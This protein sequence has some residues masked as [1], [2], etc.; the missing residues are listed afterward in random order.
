VYEVPAALRRACAPWTLPEDLGDRLLLSDHLEP[1]P[2]KADLYWVYGC[3]NGDTVLP[4]LRWVKRVLPF[5]NASVREGRA[6]HVI[7]VGHEEGWAEVWSLLGRWLG[8]NFDHSNSRRGWDDLHPASP[9]RQLASIQ[10]HGGSDYTADGKPRRRG[11]SGGAS[12]RVCFQP[13]KDVVVPGFPGIMDY[14]DDHG[15]PA[16]YKFG[17]GRESSGRISQC[18]R[19]AQ[20]QPYADG[21]RELSPRRLSPRLFMAGAIQTKTH[22]P[23]LYEASRVVPYECWKNRSKPHDFQ[24]VQTETVTVSVS[25]WEIERPVDPYP[26]TRHASLCAVPEGKIGSY[27]HRATNS[28]MLGCVPLI[29]KERFSYEILHEVIDWKSI[30]IHV[31]PAQMPQLDTIL[32]R[33]DVERLRLAGG[34][35][36]RRLLWTSIYGS[37]H[38]AEAEGGTADAFDTLMTSL[39]HPRRHFNLSEAHR[40]PRAPEMMDELF[41][42]LKR[43]GGEEC[44]HGYQCFD[45][46]RRSCFET[47][48]K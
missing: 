46:W 30:S 38:L 14:P 36:R 3:P 1:D 4:V 10:L 15:R 25:P 18:Q 12:C 13:N 28:L 20:Q 44:T 37:C 24:I 45:Q 31:P 47:Y 43:L 8:P 17:S 22:G 39:S 42:W 9:T 5:W 7:A 19:L 33:T 16:L 2:S 48:G 34:P 32:A 6:R 40:A 27:G 23:G 26:L 11:V 21:G 35:L 29:T 41:P